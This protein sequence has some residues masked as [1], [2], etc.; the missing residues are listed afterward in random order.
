MN[1]LLFTLFS[2]LLYSATLQRSVECSTSAGREAIVSSL[3]EDGGYRK[4]V[5]PDGE[6]GEG[7]AVVV[8]VNFTP[9]RFLK[10]DEMRGV[11]KM[12]GYLFITWKDPRYTFNLGNVSAVRL[13]AEDIWTPDIELYIPDSDGMRILTQK[14]LV[15]ASQS[16][17]MMWVPSVVVDSFCDHSPYFR[18]S[19]NCTLKFG[20]WVYSGHE[21]DLQIS[22]SQVDLSSY[23]PMGRWVLESATATR[24]VSFYDCCPEP[25]ISIDYNFHVVWH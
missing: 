4:L 22:G 16:G 21:L 6:S 7:S 15:V 25:Y 8:N 2:A 18:A 20:S 9:I 24:N 17:Q 19:T 13:R 11:I 14:N 23:T 3:L 10:V 12:L 5:R 1:L